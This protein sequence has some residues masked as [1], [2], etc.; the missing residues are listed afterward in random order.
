[1]EAEK[2]AL[3]VQLQAAQQMESLGRLAGG[4]A[5]DFN[6]MLA[7]ILGNT[8]FAMSRV[9]P[10]LPL[11]EDLQEI[12]TAAM[13]S[14][15]LTKQLL[16]FA[17]HQTVVPVVLDLNERLPEL[18]PM[19]RRLVGEDMR[20][21]WRPGSN[22]WPVRVDP[23]QMD[24]IAIN[25][26]L[27]AR[28]AIDIVGTIEVESANAEIDAEFCS[29]HVDAVP[30]GYV[31]ISVRDSGC[32]MDHEVMSQVFEPFFTTKGQ[33]KGIGLGLATVYG[34][35]R[36]NG[37]FITVSSK[38]GRGSVFEAYLPR[39]H[40]ETEATPRPGLMAPTAGGTETILLVEDEQAILRLIART[41][42]SLGYKVL[43]AGDPGEAIR[44]ATEYDGDL[45]LL[46]TDLV[47]PEMNGIELANELVSRRPQ[48]KRLYMSGH[49]TEVL[50]DRGLADKGVSFLEKPFS[51]QSLAAK[52]R[53]ALGGD[54]RPG[55]Q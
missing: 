37:G 17:R 25:L 12:Q 45:H 52:V 31:R 2:D 1:M 5:H 48:L 19:L 46:L 11:Y 24:Q 49:A 43:E 8:E 30:G 27:N 18:I 22:L 21:T 28:D 32:G 41:L 33:G 40:G 47:M 10:A 20:L 29:R 14:A 54:E 7:S 34:S 39:Y 26:C 42:R 38:P 3:E 44:L 23:S 36:Q 35:L 15:E 9:D 51:T 55:L 16:S 4:V 53:R 13:R 50:A 6:N